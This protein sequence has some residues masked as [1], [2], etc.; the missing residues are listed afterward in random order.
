MIL[1]GGPARE[2]DSELF[3]LHQ[4]GMLTNLKDHRHTLDYRVVPDDDGPRWHLD[5]IERVG[6][7][8]QRLMDLA[9]PGG[10]YSALW[11][12]DTDVI[13]GPGVLDRM[14]AVD[15]DVV[16]GVF[17]THSTWGGYARNWPQVWNTHPYGVSDGLMAA[18]EAGGKTEVY[19]GGACTLI[20]GRGFESRYYPIMESLRNA[21]GMWCGEDRTYCLGLEARGVKMVAVTGLPI[22]HLHGDQ[23]VEA[24]EAAREFCG[25]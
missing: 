1:A 24:R 11:M 9:E 17:W 6:L 14:L 5:K 21:G 7:K 23:P 2:T 4:D 16:F 15:A 13:C 22:V 20:R 25:L 3:R 19:G 18:L 10:E 8:R 12:V